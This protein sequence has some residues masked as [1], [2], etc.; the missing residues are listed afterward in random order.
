MVRLTALLLLFVSLVS[1]PRFVLANDGLDRYERY[2]PSIFYHLYAPISDQAGFTVL[3]EDMKGGADAAPAFRWARQFALSVTKIIA[4]ETCKEMGVSG[5]PMALFDFSAENGDTPIRWVADKPA[6][7]RHPGGSHD[8]G[9]NLDFGYYMT[10]YKGPYMDPDYSV[11]DE[12]YSDTERD[13]DGAPKD[14]HQ[15]LGPANRLDVPRQA[16]FFLR[17]FTMHQDQFHSLLLEQIGV[18]FYVKKA[19]L[20]QIADWK[21]EAVYKISDDI[22]REM[23][24][25]FTCDRW[26]GWARYHHHHCHVRFRNLDESGPHRAILEGLTER[27]RALDYELL[28]VESPDQTV[29]IK[30][31][32]LSYKLARAIDVTLLTSESTSIQ[33]CRYRLGDDDWVTADEP[34]N[35]FRYVFDLPYWP[36]MQDTHLVI[37]AEIDVANGQTSVI[38]TSVYLPQQDPLLKIRINRDAISGDY[39]IERD[40]DDSVWTLWTSFPSAYSHYITSVDYY[41]FPLG[42]FEEPTIVAGEGQNFRAHYTGARSDVLSIEAKV[43]ISTRIKHTVPIF[44]GSPSRLR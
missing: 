31:D 37:S 30:A 32:L 19:I 38:S 2:Y 26:G 3:E 35:N 1:V 36:T 9:V 44:V 24:S 23:E 34:L 33:Q 13:E 21:N 14:L 12:H 41:I 28:R 39:S 8:G 5:H 15:C 42:S 17:L 29:F 11:C 25:I 16:Y 4:H 20:G 22:V 27:V 6:R 18:D 43:A 40:G 7:G 10:G